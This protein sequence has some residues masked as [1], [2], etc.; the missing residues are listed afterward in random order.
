MRLYPPTQTISVKKI[1]ETFTYTK[2]GDKP[3][4][5]VYDYIPDLLAPVVSV[6]Y[7]SQNTYIQCNSNNSFKANTYDILFWSLNNTKI[8][9]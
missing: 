3:Y 2:S 4:S 1:L 7:A 5:L 9:T 8:W 6:R